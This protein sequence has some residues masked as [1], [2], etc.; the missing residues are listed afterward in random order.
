VQISACA[1]LKRLICA[2][3][4]RAREGSAF[5]KRQQLFCA[6]ARMPPVSNL[7]FQVISLRCSEAPSRGL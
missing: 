7:Y 5:V 1:K 4:L 3:I 2:P 6:A